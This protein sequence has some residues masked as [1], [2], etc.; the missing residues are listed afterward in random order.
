MKNTSKLIGGDSWRIK[1]MGRSSLM[2]SMYDLGNGTYEMALLL[3]EPGTYTAQLTLDYSLC[4]G[5]KN[6][7][8][9]WFRKG[10]TLKTWTI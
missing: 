7:P 10:K 8:Y 9:D 2:G 3:S 6:P 1:V 4:H 5:L